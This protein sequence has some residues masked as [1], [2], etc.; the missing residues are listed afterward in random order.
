MCETLLGSDN[1]L[2]YIDDNSETNASV[3]RIIQKEFSN[4]LPKQQLMDVFN[5]FVESGKLPTLVKLIAYAV[6][7]ECGLEAHQDVDCVFF[8]CHVMVQDSTEDRL[9]ISRVDL[10]EK[11]D[12][13][14]MV[15]M[16]PRLW[17]S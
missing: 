12:A 15:M 5:D 7:K 13:G 1:P 8:T 6:G 17:H 11:F 10:P 9:H 4:L 14:D 16:D 3:F 2:W